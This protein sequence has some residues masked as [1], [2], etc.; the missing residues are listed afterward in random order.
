MNGWLMHN[1]NT[2]TIN[3]AF[4]VLVCGNCVITVCLLCYYYCVFIIRLLCTCCI[5]CVIIV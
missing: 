5:Y 4:A 3:D 1:T 2:N